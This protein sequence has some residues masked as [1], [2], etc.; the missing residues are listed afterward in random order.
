MSQYG[1]LS[2]RGKISPTPYFFF[3]FVIYKSL[4][5][6][7]FSFILWFINNLRFTFLFHFLIAWLI[8]RPLNVA[9][10]KEGRK[11]VVRLVNWLIS[12]LRRD[13]Q[14]FSGRINDLR[15]HGETQSDVAQLL[16]IL[17]QSFRRDWGETEETSARTACLRT[18]SRNGERLKEQKKRFDATFDENW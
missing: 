11:T 2:A 17:L 10:S 5:P 14:Q 18:Q 13:W 6:L 3:Y 4:R 7:T 9:A 1:T 15:E 8:L 16:F 12:G